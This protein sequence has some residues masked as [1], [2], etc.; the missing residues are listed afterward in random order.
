MAQ[1]NLV[2]LLLELHRT[3]QSCVVRFER[4]PAKKQLVLEQGGLCYAESN[5]P[6][7]HLAHFLI[8]LGSLSRTDLKKVAELMKAGMSSDEAAVRAAGLTGEQ[9]AAGVGDQAVTILASLLSWQG[10]EPRLFSTQSLPQR[11][12]RL[13]LPLPQALVDAARRAVAARSLPASCALGSE[14]IY[15]DADP[16]ARGLLPLNGAEAYV[17]VHVLKEPAPASTLAQLLPPGGCKPEDLLQCLLLLGLLKLQC[18]SAP[19]ADAKKEQQVSGQ[20]QEMLHR[21]EVGNYY[22]I[23]S[24]PSSAQE[25]QIKSAYYEMARLYHPDRFAASRNAELRAH[26]EQLFTY[27]TAAYA[28]LGDAGARAAYDDQ[29]L[30]K[31]SLVESTLQGRAMVDA[32]REKMAH[33]LFR[34]GQAAFKSGDFT[35]AVSRLRECVWLRADVARFQHWLAVAQS[36]I[37]SLRKEAEHHFLKAIE[38]DSMNSESYLQLGQLYLKVHL[39]N[40]AEVQLKEALRWDPDNKEILRLLQEC[41]L[42]EVVE[43]R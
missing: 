27:I 23:L 17:Y 2:D 21:F 38:L 28:T 11:R 30:K 24:V 29:R 13:D 26:V 33:A 37:P 10:C 8:K 12:Y 18:G 6:E 42:P 25:S 40:K 32:D 20:V 39:P 41:T 1:P 36:E 9:L 4:G 7:E 14:V 43:K 35:K 16:G 34:A 22:E 3:R 19:S 5:V 31:E 15:A